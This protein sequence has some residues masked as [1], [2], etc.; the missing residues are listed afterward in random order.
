VNSSVA[1]TIADK[2][3]KCYF[4]SDNN[5]RLIQLFLARLFA[6]HVHCS[7]KHLLSKIIDV[8]YSLAECS[9]Y[10]ASHAD[11]RTKTDK[12]VL[13]GSAIFGKFCYASHV[14]IYLF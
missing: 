4:S 1:I 7:N 2:C 10:T 9:K 11:G 14:A 12:Q 8:A 6:L 5:A 13:D 3:Q